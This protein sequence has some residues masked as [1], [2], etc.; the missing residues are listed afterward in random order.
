MSATNPP[1]S[2]VKGH[3]TGNDFVVILD[4]D[5]SIGL[6]SERVAAI[7][8]RRFGVG[9]DGVLR[10]VPAKYIAESTSE[11]ADDLWFMDYRNADGSIAEMCG[12][13]ARV[14]AK[15]L[16]DN[17]LVEAETA[18]A[19]DSFRFESRAGVHDTRVSTNG[20]A[21]NM[22]PPSPGPT[23]TA[24]QPPPVANV[25]VGSRSGTTQSWPAQAWWMP[26]PHAVVKVDSLDEVGLLVE[27]PEVD[28][29]G[30]FP[31]GQNVEFMVDTSVTSDQ[32]AASIRIFERGVGETLSCGTGACA[33]ALALRELHGVTGP[34]DV[35]I[36]VPGG[37]VSVTIDDQGD[38]W[39]V[40]PAEFVAVG[41]FLL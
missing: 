10:V 25:A 6:S 14:F 30:L 41:K 19:V 39:L 22:G 28:S 27:A 3:G 23:G 4:R 29:D 8:D 17:E 1:L 21:I 18:N 37:K 9:A 35:A 26:N 16:L 34:G 11:P 7:S 31:D 13:G 12:N 38:V 40:G 2:F 5:G 15:F 20:I 24:V 36:S 32:L 33:A